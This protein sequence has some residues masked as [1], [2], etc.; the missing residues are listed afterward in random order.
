VERTLPPPCVFCRPGG[1]GTGS[2][3]YSEMQ[4]T[5]K[6]DIH[7][8]HSPVTP[9]GA[10]SGGQDLEDK[11]H[12]R[13]YPRVQRDDL[14]RA[15][16]FKLSA[17]WVLVGVGAYDRFGS[18]NAGAAKAWDPVRLGFRPGT[19]NSAFQESQLHQRPIS[20]GAPR[21][22]KMRLGEARASAKIS[23]SPRAPH[24]S[25]N[26]ERSRERLSCLSQRIN[27]HFP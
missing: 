19:R 24:A 10:R 3:P 2:A 7:S 20:V 14:R 12:I 13:P 25:A 5:G 6:Q 4:A 8:E 1:P 21:D 15:V 16:N 17:E 23:A 9:G 18:S 11:A 26:P 22:I 27:W